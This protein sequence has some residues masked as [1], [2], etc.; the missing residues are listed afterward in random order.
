M[1]RRQQRVDDTFVVKVELWPVSSD[2]RSALVY[3]RSREHMT[4]LAASPELIQRV[5]GKSK[6]FWHATVGADR[7]IMLLKPATWRPW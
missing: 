3:D 5:K 2:Y 7:R 1:R 6:S 4:Q